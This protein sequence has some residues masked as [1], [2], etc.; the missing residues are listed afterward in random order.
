MILHGVFTY[1]ELLGDLAVLHVLSHLR[2]NFVFSL[3]QDHPSPGVSD[4]R[5][6]TIRQSLRSPPFLL[7]VGPHLALVNGHDA[8]VQLLSRLGP[9]TDSYGTRA[10]GRDHG[11]TLI[12]V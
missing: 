3:R 4:K 10:K 11:L 8:L 1:M 12:L 2:D 7:A 6:E 9:L 5:W